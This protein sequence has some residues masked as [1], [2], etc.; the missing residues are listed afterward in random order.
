[1]LSVVGHDA[2]ALSELDR[3]AI[4]YIKPGGNW[5]DLPEDFPSA[6]VQQIRKGAE[7]G[8]GTRSSYYGRLTWSA[9]AS[10]IATY[11]VRPGNGA[12]IHP[13]APRTLTY[14]E[15]A[16]L[17]GFQDK[18]R[19]HGSRRSRA[20]Q[21]GNAVPPPVA[22]WL[23]SALPTR[24]LAVELFAG[25]GGLGAGI[26]A[27]GFETLAVADIDQ[28]ALK[29]LGSHLSTLLPARPVDLSTEHR[30]Q[31]FVAEVR[32]GAGGERVGLVAGGPPCQGFSTAGNNRLFD[33][34]RNALP[35]AFLWVV[36]EL[37]PRQVLFEN[38]A[39]LTWKSRRP[40]FNRLLRHLADAGYQVEWRLVHCE[41]YGLPQ[42]R[43]RV[44][45]V[46]TDQALP[47]YEFPVAP[48]SMETPCYRR[49]A[50]DVS[51]SAQAP[52]NVR[53]AIGDLPEEA[54]STATAPVQ[55]V[56]DG[57]DSAFRRYVRG[58]LDLV[59]LIGA[60]RMAHD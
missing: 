39:A 54:A 53:D 37:R 31:D 40:W 10:T 56:P 6:R 30:R 14:R 60:D 28:S 25:A 11:F 2:G 20:T 47:R 16:R 7:E 35:D 18:V 17:Q 24:G 33:D 59:G 23:A 44:V 13:S 50:Q 12:N 41:A 58:D 19:F 8:T 55:L 49:H 57:V 29:T 15:A 26:A 21:I 52:P 38:V 32:R 27:A 5:R 22:A 1:M 43:R 9:S 42:R 4:S 48:Y 36:E 34:P 51:A 46:G 3:L 45:V